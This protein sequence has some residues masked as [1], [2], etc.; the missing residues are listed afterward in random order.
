MT[1]NRVTRFIL[2]ALAL[3]I[4]PFSRF[5]FTASADTTPNHTTNA[6]A[7]V[8]FSFEVTN[9]VKMAAVNEVTITLSKN[10][11]TETPVFDDGN[12]LS[13]EYSV[14]YS[15]GSSDKNATVK[16]TVYDVGTYIFT[17]KATLEN[18]DYSY[19]EQVNVGSDISVFNAPSYNLDDA[20]LQEY[21]AQVLENTF[22]DGSDPK[23]NLRINDSYVVPSLEKLL[24]TEFYT[25]AKYRKTV[26]YTAPND[27]SY[28]SN[29]AT[30]VA[31]ITFKISKLGE[32]RFYVTFDADTVDGKDFDLTTTYT[33][34]RGDGFYKITRKDN[35]EMLY[36]SLN[37][38]TYKYF[39]DKELLTE[40][41]GEVDATL[42]VP[43]F[44]FTIENNA[45]PSIK[46]PTYQ[47]PGYIG[48]EYKVKN[49]TVGG[50]DINVTYT[51]Q[52]NPVSSNEDHSGWVV[53]EEEYNEDK[54]SFTPEKQGFY[55]VKVYV[56][57]GDGNEDT[58]YTKAIS[59]TDKYVNVDYKVSFK[60]WVKANTLPFIFLCISGACLIAIVLLLVI[61]PKEKTTDSA[62]GEDL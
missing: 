22:I 27:T 13:D 1:K 45:G 46:L 38:T 42:V 19:V 41:T 28:S 43:V 20:L 57:D 40:Y 49:I 50:S 17:V 2:L 11:A 18:V 39:E 44:T 25:Y 23:Q 21:K 62:D 9:E 59:V 3:L 54:N 58:Q 33:E 31:D 35:G 48:L 34:E 60:D 29:S 24:N 55:R 37:G 10:G 4:M 8:E 52:Y 32:Y 5:T 12:D 36:A 15:V 61:K 53:A 7:G 47:D 14:A 56:I 16:A 6:Y 51:L 30:G 26:Y